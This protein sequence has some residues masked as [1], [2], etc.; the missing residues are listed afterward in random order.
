MRTHDQNQ[1]RKSMIR[2]RLVA[3]AVAIAVLGAFGTMG[4][5]AV[6]TATPAKTVYTVVGITDVHHNKSGDGGTFRGELDA[7][8]PV[9]AGGV[10]SD[11]PAGTAAPAQSNPAPATGV[12][13]GASSGTAYIN[14]NELAQVSEGC[15][16]ELPPPTKGQGLVETA[17]G[18]I[19]GGSDGYIIAS[20]YVKCGP[21]PIQGMNFYNA[22]DHSAGPDGPWASD[23]DSNGPFSGY[24]STTSSYTNYVYHTCYSTTNHWYYRSAAVIEVHYNGKSFYLDNEATFYSP[25]LYTTC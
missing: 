3:N 11:V 6:A 1:K 22:I 17:F 24:R 2:K 15:V 25:N 13:T 23:P 5:A 12:T 19:Y 4:G 21:N 9:G 20:V 7:T 8:A 18:G 10:P 14:N 16:Y